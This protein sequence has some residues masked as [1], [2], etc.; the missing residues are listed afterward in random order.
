[1]FWT[2]V[3]LRGSLI[4]ML[5]ISV[6][7]L[8]SPVV[9][10]EFE[11]IEGE[12]LAGLPR[13][14]EATA[15]PELT[16]GDLEALPN[17]LRDTRSAFLVATTDQGN[18]TRLLVVPGL[19]KPPGGD[20]APIPVVV[21]E[22]FDTFD[23]GNRANRLARGRDL[24]LFDGFQVDLDSG[25]VVPDGQGGDLRFQTQ[26]ESGPRL[27]SVGKARLYSLK[28]LPV[29]PDPAHDRPSIGRIVLP[30]DFNGRYR[31]FA[32][33][34][35]S[36]TLDLKIEPDPVGTNSVTGRFRSD[37][38]GA[39]YPVTGQVAADVPQ[40]LTFRIKLPRTHQDFD[41]LLW[42]EGKGAIAGTMTMIDHVF[43]FFALREGGRYAPEG[44]DTGLLASTRQATPQGRRTVV[45]RKGEYTLDGK[46][47]TDLELTSLLKKAVAAEPATWVL[48]QVPDDEPFSAIHR[49][50]AAL[51]AAGVTNI[52][53]GSIEAPE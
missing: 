4:G 10:D 35:W 12:A 16:M 39:T 30:T 5:G 1:M 26:G 25:Q 6:F 53:L 44:E 34:Q 19:R 41:G 23:A 43:G 22:R 31:L 51:G 14:S 50:Y 8:V 47:R 24:I 13:D 38:S 21:L 7:L 33:G 2:S 29:S 15:R 52:R 11:R 3:R 40:R 28:K 48:L 9:G 18:V 49:A 46:P 20:Q 27:A 32:N 36:G 42:T 17:L 45:I 37:T